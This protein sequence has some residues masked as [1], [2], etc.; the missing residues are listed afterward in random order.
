METIK[1]FF[2]APVFEGDEDKTRRAYL[3]HVILVAQTYVLL[4]SAAGTLLVSMYDKMRLAE[5]LIMI[6]SLLLVALWRI[7]MRRGQ[8][9]AASVGMLFFFTFMLY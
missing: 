2:S 3:L 8:V 7:L 4:F 6:A 1:R 9:T 5:I